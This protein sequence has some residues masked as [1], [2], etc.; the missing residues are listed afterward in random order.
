MNR[1][2]FYDALR[3]RNSGLFGT[4]MSQK[5]V[6]G[7]NAVLNEA[8][9]RGIILNRLAYALATIYHE[10]GAKMQPV[11]ENLNYSVSGLLKTFGRHRIS[12]ADA[13]RYGRSGSRKADQVAIANTIYG[14]AWGAKNLGNTQPGDGWRFRA[15]GLVGRTGRANFAKVGMAHDPE[16][17]LNLATSVRVD[18][19]AMETGTFTGKK[20]SDFISI[21]AFDFVG[22]RKVINGTDK[23]TLIAGYAVAFRTALVAAGYG[24][25]PLPDV[26]PAPKP[27]PALPSDARIWKLVVLI[28][29][30]LIGAML[31]TFGKDL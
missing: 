24:A 4:R 23:A 15:M 30:G 21:K 11:A 18:L 31:F 12:E 17:M 19:E 20:L 7:M 13:R 22:A 3:K 25:V 9:R 1:K 28:V 14:G 6:D 2:A 10:T 27:V 29:I 26:E 5:Q 16:A 8:L